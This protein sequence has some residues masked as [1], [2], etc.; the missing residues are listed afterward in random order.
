VLDKTRVKE[1]FLSIIPLESANAEGYFKAV[2]EEMKILGC[3]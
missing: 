3:E 1:V 2:D